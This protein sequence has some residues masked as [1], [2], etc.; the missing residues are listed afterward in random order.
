LSHE[1]GLP[2]ELTANSLCLTGSEGSTL[3]C[4]TARTSEIA[5]A[6]E[7]PAQ[8][9]SVGVELSKAERSAL[10]GASVVLRSQR[11][12]EGQGLPDF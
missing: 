3:S 12:G 10:T 8:L 9:F 1:L 11:Y 6:V 7:L 4:Y 5:P 2:L